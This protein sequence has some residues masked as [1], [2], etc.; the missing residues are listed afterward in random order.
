MELVASPWVLAGDGLLFLV[1]LYA[2]IFAL[3]RLNRYSGSLKRLVNVVALSLTL[4]TVGRFLDVL[5]DFSG[6]PLFLDAIIDFL[7]FV[8]IIEVVYGLIRY[9]S[10]IE[11]TLS[12]QSP[13]GSFGPGGYLF[14]GVERDE[15]VNFLQA[16]SYPVLVFTRN[17]EGYS[18]IGEHISSVWVTPVE[19]GGIH[20]TKLHLM[21]NKS[22][23]FLKSGGK[24][25]VIDCLEALIMYN[26][27]SSV[28][29]FLATLKDYVIINGA[30]LV[31]LSEKETLEERQLRVL[32]RELVPAKSLRFVI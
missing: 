6:F 18:S 5:N 26:D 19:N 8:S 32:L 1:M 3:K 13:E 24:V 25:I 10:E 9:I 30:V 15:I 14:V 11:R 4:A 7:Y 31:V 22:L 27:F 2:T 28:F 12:P 16:V 17:P 20:P 21:L 29:R 23:R